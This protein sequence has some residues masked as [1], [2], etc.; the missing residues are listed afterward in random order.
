MAS[1]TGKLV[2]VDL[3]TTF[4]A[5]AT[6]DDNGRPVT[7]PNRDGDMLTPSAVLLLDDGTAVVGQAALDVALEQP[8]R[9]A[10]LV[11]RR[12]GY[13]GFGRPVAGREFR[14][15]TLS[16]IILRKIV[17]DAELRLGPIAGAVI[18]VPAYFDDTRRKA[19][20]DAGLIAGLNVLDILD[21]P[22]AAALA[23]SFQPARG[24]A[25]LNAD[26]ILPGDQ[27]TVLV[28]DL[29]GGTFDVTLV[30]L[31]QRRFQ[32]LAIEGDVRLGGKD[33]DDR[34]VDHVAQQF[35]EQTGSD[36]R[37]DPL[38][39]ANLQSAAERAKRTLSKLPQTTV[40]C[41]HAGRVLT[42]PLTRP[43]FESLTRDLLV[44]TRLTAQQLL[45]QA[46]LTWD[47]VDRLLLVGGSTH[48]PMTGQM[49]RELTGKAPD[50]SLAVSEVVAR[51]A[52]LHA[53]IV[54]SRSA[55]QSPNLDPKAL[56]LLGEVVEINVNAHSLGIEV[57]NQQDERVN[58]VL[59][60][61]NT[62]L[63]TA[64]SR[65]YYTKAENQHKVRVKVLQGDAAQADACISIGECWVEELPPN[66]P[67]YSPV[68]VRYGVSSNGLI[69]VMALDMTSG[70][71]ARTEIHRSSGLSEDEVAREAEWVAGLQIQ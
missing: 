20:K 13:P 36:P 2:G 6:L 71:M 54:A 45:R 16:A 29:G 5:I 59:I 32:T 19:T 22:T 61:K 25:G 46:G 33:W 57:K 40:T 37:S 70:K 23:Y 15:E 68:Q 52:A 14:P 18:T 31:A 62:Q 28:Y 67:Q 26:Q 43:D 12:M 24:A 44:R 34:V 9:V 7:L 63:P 4:S 64:A 42:V 56:A 8:D 50:N 69:D 3:G 35:A 60:P 17:Q 49:L 48:M 51:G 41:A 58:D 27:Q 38:S 47:Q 1:G 21:E 53:G 11:K 30:R 66:L 55:E 65:V 10:T 39:L